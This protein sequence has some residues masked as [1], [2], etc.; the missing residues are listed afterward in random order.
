[1]LCS[2]ARLGIFVLLLEVQF[3]K[4]IACDSREVQLLFVFM[5]CVA[6]KNFDLLRK[7]FRQITSLLLV[8]GKG[9]T[10]L[11]IFQENKTANLP[12]NCI[13]TSYICLT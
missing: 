9:A 11:T 12:I 10:L 3:Q 4:G 8:E 13:E 7:F 1:M 2:A 6:T 5:L